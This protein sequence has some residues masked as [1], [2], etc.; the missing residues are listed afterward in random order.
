MKI[1]SLSRLGQ[2][3]ARHSHCF[4]VG[5]L[6]KIMI[7]LMLGFVKSITFNPDNVSYQNRN[8]ITW[9][10]SKAHWMIPIWH[11]ILQE[12]GN[13]V[14]IYPNGWSDGFSTLCECK[15]TSNRWKRVKDY[16]K[17]TCFDEAN[18]ICSASW[19]ADT[20]GVAAERDCNDN[21]KTYSFEVIKHFQTKNLYRNMV[22]L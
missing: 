1:Q 5:R 11:I 4:C 13:Y 10:I 16:M 7:C 2:A 20:A 18:W 21:W 14:L 9:I 17:C 19:Q 15:V 12:F 8:I 3:H 6:S 22:K